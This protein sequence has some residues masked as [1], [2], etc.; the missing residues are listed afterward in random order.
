MRFFLA[1]ALGAV[2]LAMPQPTV[3]PLPNEKRQTPAAPTATASWT[4]NPFEG[5]SLWANAY[6][7]SEVSASAIPSLTGAMATAAA[8][9][10]KVPSFMWL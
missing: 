4:G 7:A 5:V 1:A 6:Y 8:A 2:A 3:A 10:A 9:V